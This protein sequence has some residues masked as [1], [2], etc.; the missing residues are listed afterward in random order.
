MKICKCFKMLKLIN[1][2][3]IK[4][5]NQCK[6]IATPSALV[7][8]LKL[9]I[10]RN[11]LRE[12]VLCFE[13]AWLTSLLLPCSVLFTCLLLPDPRLRL[14]HSANRL[15]LRSLLGLSLR[16]HSL[17]WSSLPVGSLP[18]SKDS[19]WN[20]SLKYCKVSLLLSVL[21]FRKLLRL[22]GLLT[23]ISGWEGI[24]GGT[25]INVGSFF[26]RN[27]RSNSRAGHAH[28]PWHPLLQ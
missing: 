6:F 2:F 28:A 27:S 5:D 23:G 18:A 12:S 7:V 10:P 1:R 26:L 3:Q 19:R 8:F 4:Q 16:V 20:L 13:L 11:T 21:F 9:S 22:S 15:L 24:S 17:P 14:R 25:G